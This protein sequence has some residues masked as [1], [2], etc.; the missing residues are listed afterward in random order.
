MEIKIL[1]TYFFQKNKFIGVH[2]TH[3]LRKVIKDSNKGYSKKKLRSL[4]NLDST[5]TVFMVTMVYS[6][7]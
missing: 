3:P 4:F 2:K 6:V 1:I 7:K 5:N